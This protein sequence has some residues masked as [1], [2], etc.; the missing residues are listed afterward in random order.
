MTLSINDTHSLAVSSVI[1]P[2][3]AFFIVTVYT[4]KIFVTLVSDEQIF[5]LVAFFHRHLRNIDCIMAHTPC[6]V[7]FISTVN[8]RSKK[9]KKIILLRAAHVAATQQN[10]SGLYYLDVYAYLKWD[11]P[12][13]L[14]NVIW[15]RSDKSYS[16]TVHGATTFDMTTLSIM[17]VSFT[18]NKR[19][20]AKWHSAKWH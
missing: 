2:S 1:T 6:L 11:L 12:D 7:C 19:H 14:I 5:F 16:C 13:N 3:V 20:S 9:R 17:A 18:I 4:C 15:A 10:F 8:S